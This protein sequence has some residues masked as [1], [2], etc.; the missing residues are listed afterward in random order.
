[1]SNLRLKDHTWDAANVYDSALGKT[2]EQINAEVGTSLAGKQGTLVSGETIKTVNGAS[3]LG[4]G[5]IEIQ[6]GGGS[7]VVVDDTLS[8]AGAAADAKKTG[9]E[10]SG[11]KN[12]INYL[13]KD[14][15]AEFIDGGYIRTDIAT[16]ITVDS[17]VENA[18]YRYAVAECEYG[19]WCE[20]HTDGAG[21]AQAFA[22]VDE[23]GNKIAGSGSN[24]NIDRIYIAPPNAKYLVIN[25]KIADT[26]YSAHIGIPVKKQRKIDDIA[27]KIESQI[28]QGLH[29]DPNDLE[30]EAGAYT[31]YGGYAYYFSYPYA[32]DSIT[33]LKSCP[34]AFVLLPKWT[35]IKTD[36]TT[37][38][39][40]VVKTFDGQISQTTWA[41]SLVV[42]EAAYYMFSIK[43]ADNSAITDVN[44]AVSTLSINP[45]AYAQKAINNSW[46]NEWFLDVSHQGYTKEAPASTVAAFCRAKARGYNA[47]ECDLRITSDGEF[48][49]NHNAAM[50][51]D[52]SYYIANHTL[53]ELRANANMGTYDNITQQILTFEDVVKIAKDLDMRVFAEFKADF[54]SAQIEAVMNIAKQYNMQDRVYWMGSYNSQSAAYAGIFRGFNPDCNLLIFDTVDPANIS[55]FV[56][57]GKEKTFCYAR[58]TYITKTV[59][60]NMTAIGV[61][62]IAWCVSFSWLLPDFTEE[63][64]IQK[65]YDTLDCGISGICL[66]KWTTAE[67]VRM[68]YAEYF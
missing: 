1:M 3:I 23:N 21:A 35:E 48:V 25:D 6:G 26:D 43:N 34:N 58:C 61:P 45:P 55:P 60:E 15:S 65:I 24:V 62:T 47:I 27:K 11:L 8:I 66:D 67:L 29:I 32:P 16:G 68:R 14:L 49:I 36:G 9:D 18:G 44:A 17:P 42:P 40:C 63:Q 12:T 41:D 28:S 37:Q 59:V 19:D 31:T 46:K 30:F 57:A 22:F 52:S 4:S 53:A 39:Y 51:S 20:I 50:P 54:T 10:I 5:N 7:S 2:Q 13:S 38:F 56:I 33:R 64:V